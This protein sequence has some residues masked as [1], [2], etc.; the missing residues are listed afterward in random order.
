MNRLPFTTQPKVAEVFARYPVSVRKKIEQLQQLIL[1]TAQETEGVTQ[2][3]ESLKWGEPSY[4]APKG[5]PSRID[6]KEKSPQQYA[7]Y[8][9]C[10]SKLVPTFRKVYEDTFRRQPSPCLWLG[11]G[12]A[13]GRVEAL[14]SRL[15]DLPSGQAPAP[16]GAL[17]APPTVPTGKLRMDRKVGKLHVASKEP[18]GIVL[19]ALLASVTVTLSLSPIFG[20]QTG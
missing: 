9:Q 11:R 5:S 17:A 6:W 15:F 4:R 2:L 8:V 1:D 13:S 3:E 7:M 18:L 10:T 20:Q 16:A 19:F 12:P 14:H